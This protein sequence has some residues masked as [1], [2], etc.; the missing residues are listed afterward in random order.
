MSFTMGTAYSVLRVK[1]F[2][3]RVGAGVN[4][5]RER[6]GGV[7]WVWLYNVH[8]PWMYLRVE[9]VAFGRLA[10]AEFVSSVETVFCITWAFVHT[11]A[12]VYV[13]LGCTVCAFLSVHAQ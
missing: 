3:I 11:H 13:C 10:V 4:V 2:V 6:M 1:L 9:L 5:Q 7:R 12:H 8:R